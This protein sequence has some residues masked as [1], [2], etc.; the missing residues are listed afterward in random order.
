AMQ[1]LTAGFET[2]ATAIGSAIFLFCTHPDQR[3]KL[4]NDWALL[5]TAVEEV[6]RFESPVEG[7]FRTAT[8]PVTIGGTDLPAGAKVRVVYASAN[9]DTERFTDPDAFRIDRPA[10]ELRR[11]IAFGSG[12][13]ACIG[14][15]LARAELQ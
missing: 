4:A 8:C 9:R 6:L 15:A 3:A 12:P 7:T 10:A 5:D 11:H 2:T 1:F 13:H 14:S